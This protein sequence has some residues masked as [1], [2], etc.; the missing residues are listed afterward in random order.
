MLVLCVLLNVDIVIMSLPLLDSSLFMLSYAML[1]ALHFFPDFLIPCDPVFKGPFLP[2][3]DL[4][5]SSRAFLSSRRLVCG[6]CG[7]SGAGKRT[8]LL[9][10]LVGLVVFVL[11]ILDF[12][13]WLFVVDW[14]GTGWVRLVSRTEDMAWVNF[15]PPCP[16]GMVAVFCWCEL[17]GCS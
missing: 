4:A 13:L 1:R 7:I 5:I 3:W 10:E 17:C 8:C 9:L 2:A 15:S 16:E 6:T 12:L 14:V 11:V